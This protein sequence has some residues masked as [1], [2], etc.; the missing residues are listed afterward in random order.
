MESVAVAQQSVQTSCYHCGLP[1]PE[2]ADFQLTIDGQNQ[3]F[4][5]PGCQ[6]VASAIHEGGLGKFY[7]YRTQ[8]NQ[9]PDSDASDFAVYDLESVQQDFVF[10]Q[11]DRILEAQLLVE[12]ITCAA[13]VWLI[14]HHIGNLAG[15]SKVSVNAT[16]HRC[17]VQWNPEQIPLSQIMAGMSAIG[18]NPQPATENR[19]QSLRDKENR[20]A[21]LRLGV[22]GIGM[23]QVGMFAVA[24]YAGALQ[25]ISAE[26]EAFFRWVS[27]FVATPVVF[28]SAQPFFQGAFRVLKSR[29]LSMD[30]SISLAII[31]AYLAS[32]WSTIF[33]YGEVYFDSVSMFTFF[34]LLGRYLEMHA[35]HRNG[36]ET[37]RLA[38]L[39][40]VAVT[41][42]Q[43]QEKNEPKIEDVAL[44]NIQ[45]GD[46]LRINPGDTF[47]CDGIVLE[48]YSQAV[49]ALLTGE[50]EPVKK[51][52][53]DSVIAGTINQYNSLVIEVIAIGS[54]T[55][56]SA[57]ERLV[58]QALAK[59]PK[60]VAMADRLAGLFVGAVI[61]FTLIV[62]VVWWQIA[63]DRAFEVCLSVL[64][65]TC[66]CALS[67]AT[68][69]ALT[70]AIST[71]RR[72]GFL[73]TNS[74]VLEGLQKVKRVIFDK[75]GTLTRGL[76]V[77]RNVILCDSVS[78][79]ECLG[80][81]AAL[82]AGS[83][84][85][86]AKAF[87]DY[88]G[89]F[90]AA[91]IKMKTAAGLEGVV[92]EEVYRIGSADYAAALVDSHAL[93]SAPPENI[94]GQ[95]LL[96]S[97]RKSLLAWINISDELRESAKPAIA[98]LQRRGLDIELLSGD[99]SRNVEKVADKLG[100][101]HYSAGVDPQGKLARIRQHQ[102]NAEKVLMVGDGI[103]DIPVLSG[104]DVSI[105]M[106]SASDLAQTN[107]DSVLLHGN[108]NL[109][110]SVIEFSRLTRKIIHQ[111]ISWAILYN[112]T[113]L[114][115]AAAGLVPPYAAAI[116]MSVSSLVVVLNALRLGKLNSGL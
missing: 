60:Q 39:L 42:V 65:V 95:W 74:L 81:A 110:P 26:W 30:V 87:A 66:P 8:T 6:A 33:E 73:I 12:G 16:T 29:H 109:I 58:D 9:K 91:D 24:L 68:P 2:G 77:I 63:P 94:Q 56:L 115:L 17:S 28:F 3:S 57:I 96:L 75:T 41:R 25:G 61:L 67:L 10:S 100:I 54:Q 4:C 97:S 98:S 31:G 82:E 53:G 40:P 7:Q 85:P 112:L 48:G 43:Y 86:I 37:G 106:G 80:I 107:A 92:G 15:V 105:A 62:A 104:A 27:M 36:E 70:S 23:M 103:N 38:E 78:K 101:K 113:A 108:L 22:A 21:L 99:T 93:P 52:I 114:P 59:K 35:R 51:E 83:N 76:P 89:R 13:C 111:N 55:Q 64:V 90:Y 116:G 72:H 49:E 84:H 34:L 71:L 50:S 5:C 45:V 18:Y 69:A 32:C 79:D 88:S 19:A 44:K 11:S 20:I 102:S 46:C 1:V 14:E 47:P